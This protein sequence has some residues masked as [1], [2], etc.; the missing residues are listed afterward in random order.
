MTAREK[1]LTRIKNLLDMANDASSANEAMIAAR[2]ARA[3]MDKH[4]ISKDDITTATNNTFDAEKASSS[5]TSTPSWVRLIAA[6]VAH[7]NECQSVITTK[8]RR[9]F[10]EFRGFK[11]DAIIA[12]YMHDYL[13]NTC[14]RL[15]N[16]SGIKGRSNRNYYRL[17]FADEIN[18]RV[19]EI[20]AER[21]NIKSKAGTG[22]IILKRQLV[23]AH[24]EELPSAR[25]PKSRAPSNSERE[26]FIK[27]IFDASSV[28][29]NI[30]VTGKN[31]NSIGL[32][33]G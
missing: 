31:Q 24:F 17:G 16:K 5:Y 4:Q 1:L 13:I 23:D 21:E 6:S 20:T 32:Q 19:N 14:I 25:K 9:V 28:S 26:H 12:K 29:L 7:M 8:Y 27:G 3:L 30:Q 10:F 22:L 18:R 33:H 11:S 15:E 2:R